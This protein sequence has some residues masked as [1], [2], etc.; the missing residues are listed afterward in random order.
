MR[1]VLMSELQEE[2]FAEFLKNIS[3]HNIKKV[4]IV[5]Y[6]DDE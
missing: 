6:A 5:T 1:C 3:A 2:V 4:F